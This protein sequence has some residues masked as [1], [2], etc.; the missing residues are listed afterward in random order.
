[1]PWFD[2]GFGQE[3]CAD[4]SGLQCNG[5]PLGAPPPLRDRLRAKLDGLGDAPYILFVGLAFLWRRELTIDIDDGRML[6][7]PDG[8]NSTLDA[9]TAL[10][11]PADGQSWR[12]MVRLPLDKTGDQLIIG[13]GVSVHAVG[14][15]CERRSI[16]LGTSPLCPH[17]PRSVTSYPQFL[18]SAALTTPPCRPRATPSPAPARAPRSARSSS[19]RASRRTVRG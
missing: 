9:A 8:S 15:S 11:Q 5:Q 4:G 13:D 16:G 1:M 18:E 19:W 3:E 2:P 10:T 7:G 12:A 17:S 6:L 14:A